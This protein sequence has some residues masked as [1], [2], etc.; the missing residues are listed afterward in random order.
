MQKF[1]QCFRAVFGHA[2]RMEDRYHSGY[3]P[4]VRPDLTH[5]KGA[6][7]G[8]H[9][10]LY[11][12]KVTSPL[13][14]SEGGTGTL[15]GRV[16]FGN[17]AEEQYEIILGTPPNAADGSPG[18]RGVYDDA[19]RGG[20]R[21][22]PLVLETFGGFHPDAARLVETLARKHGAR[23]GADELSAPWNARSFR[24]LHLQRISVALQLAAAEEILDTILLDRGAAVRDGCAQ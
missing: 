6:P 4:T 22:C 18:R 5:L 12:L 19:L 8:T 14:L 2:V 16:G 1:L 24:T 7:D 15:G 10:S 13:A 20:H 21:V 23:L 3:S 11:E 9:H 17:T